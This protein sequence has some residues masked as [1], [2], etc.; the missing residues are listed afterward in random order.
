MGERERENASSPSG[1][2]NRWAEKW[3]AKNDPE[4][5]SSTA[6]KKVDQSRTHSRRRGN[7]R[8]HAEIGPALA[9]AVPDV[10]LID[11]DDRAE[12]NTMSPIGLRLTFPV[13]TK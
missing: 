3:L 10:R 5:W 9:V 11:R 6:D 4:G 7:E 1:P 2:P 12:A 13:S 8:A